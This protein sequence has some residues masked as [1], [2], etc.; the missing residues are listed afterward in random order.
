MCTSGM[1]SIVQEETFKIFQVKL[2]RKTFTPTR[3]VAS[4]VTALVISDGLLFV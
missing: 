4:W 1:H 2:P 3:T